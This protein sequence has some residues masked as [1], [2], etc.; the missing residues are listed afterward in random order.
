MGIYVLCLPQSHVCVFVCV[1]MYALLWINTIGT[2]YFLVLLSVV[3]SRLN[4]QKL[5]VPKRRHFCAEG[6]GPFRVPHVPSNSSCPS[7]L[8]VLS[9]I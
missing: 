7:I 6:L 4:S 1:C 8:F 5:N 3:L 9:V 2:K